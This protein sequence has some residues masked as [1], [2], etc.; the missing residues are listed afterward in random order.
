MHHMLL[1]SA[2]VLNTGSSGDEPLGPGRQRAYPE[3]DGGFKIWVGRKLGQH[4]IWMAKPAVD[5]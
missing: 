2:G 5:Q 3:R 1:Y 4:S